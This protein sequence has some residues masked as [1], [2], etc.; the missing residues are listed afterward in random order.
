MGLPAGHF[1]KLGDGGARWPR[2]LTQNCRNPGLAHTAVALRSR[3]SPDVR[4]VGGIGG[5]LWCSAPRPPRRSHDPQPRRSPG[6]GGG[7]L[8][9]ESPHSLDRFVGNLSYCRGLLIGFHISLVTP[10]GL[11]GGGP[12]VSPGR[13]PTAVHDIHRPAS[14]RDA[15]HEGAGGCRRSSNRRSP[16]GPPAREGMQIDALVFER[17]PQPFD[18]DVIE[19]PAAPIHRDA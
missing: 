6:R 19:E 3:D 2:K 10:P 8:R 11:S 5:H 17:A 18:E 14:R 16:G 9:P 1:L 12:G 13:R 7:R 15:R 4:R